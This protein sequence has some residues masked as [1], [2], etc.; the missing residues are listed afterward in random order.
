MTGLSDK[1]QAFVV[2]L[3]AFLLS[4]GT[5]G[6]ALPSFI[7]DEYKAPFAITFWICG[8]LGLALK[9]ALGSQS[10]ASATPAP[11]ATSVTNLIPAPAYPQGLVGTYS[12]PRLGGSWQIF[13]IGTNLEI[14]PPAD[15]AAQI[16][17]ASENVGSIAGY[18][19]NYTD[20]LSLAK[21]EIDRL[22]TNALTPKS[23]VKTPT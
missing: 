21:P 20:W 2:S 3:S 16:G 12:E 15:K 14:V 8:I 19:V 13:I 22:V 9:E 11:T 6:A 17:I 10:P 4:L 1:M 23:G 7:P 18:P 5:A